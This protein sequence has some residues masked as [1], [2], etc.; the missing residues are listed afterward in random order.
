MKKN[1]LILLIASFL[2]SSAAIAFASA[3]QL[4][5]KDS[6][7]IAETTLAQNKIDPSQYFIFSVTYTNS[8]KGYFWYYTYRLINNPSVGQEL[9]LKIYM[10]KTVEVI[11]G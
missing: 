10:D 6:I 7:P 5:L 11:T 2:I 4:L 1:L 9:H 8:S 3:P